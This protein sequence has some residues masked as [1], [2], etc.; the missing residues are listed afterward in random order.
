MMSCAIA[1]KNN[2][3]R[4]QQEKRRI[5]REQESWTERFNKNLDIFEKN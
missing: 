1:D 5:F 2:R 4:S 3:R